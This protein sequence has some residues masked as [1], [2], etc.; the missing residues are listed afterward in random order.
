MTTITSRRRGASVVAVSAVLRRVI[1]ADGA[2]VGYLD[3]VD[4]PAGRRWR[5]RRWIAQQRRAVDVGEFW[6][7]DDALDAL[8]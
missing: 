4:G 6:R 7:V 8:R 5:A 3:A 1:G 2:L